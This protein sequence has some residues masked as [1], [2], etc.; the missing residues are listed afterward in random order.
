MKRILLS[1]LFILF[2]GCPI[3]VNAKASNKPNETFANLVFFA[4]YDGTSDE[5]QEDIKYYEK[6]NASFLEYYEGTTKRSLTN[7]LK[8]ISYGKFEVKNIFPQL[9][10]GKI[11]PIKFNIDIKD[12][13]ERNNDSALIEQIITAYPSLSN[14]MVDYNGDGYIDNLTIIIK[15]RPNYT[16]ATHSS[17]VSHKGDYPEAK[18]YLNKYIG[19]YNIV[20]TDSIEGNESGVIAHEFLH[21]LGYPD[22]YRSDA[23]NN[24]YP[25]DVWDIMASANRGM[26]YPL[27]YL[28]KHISNWVDIETITEST[29]LRLDLQSNPDGN[30][31]FILKSPLNDYEYFVVE[32]RKKDYN[33][34]LL[35][36]HIG[37]SGVIV[38]RVDT[39]VEGLSNHYG[40][41][42]VYVFRPQ[43]GFNSEQQKVYY[44]ALSQEAKRTSIGSSN[45]NLGL[46]DGALTFSDGS[47]S[48]IVIKNVSKAGGDFMTLDV[49]IPKAENFDLWQNK[50]LPDL[51]GGN[52]NTNKKITITNYKDTVYALSYGNNRLY[53]Q[54][55]ENNNWVTKGTYCNI[56]TEVL[57]NIKVVELNDTLYLIANHTNAI[58]VY[59]WN[60]SNHTWNL[61]SSYPETLNE[62]EVGV[63]QNKIY[64]AGS[65]SDKAVLYVL[66]HN[67]ITK[68]GDYYSGRNGTPKIGA[69]HDKVYVSIKSMDGDVLLY[70]YEANQFI[71]ISTG[72]N[73]NNYDLK[74][75]NHKLYI[76][77]GTNGLIHNPLSLKIF[78]GT[79]WETVSSSLT[80]SFPTMVNSQGNLYILGTD[81]SNLYTY[82]YQEDA[83]KFILEGTVVDTGSS[84]YDTSLVALNKSI[85]VG[86]K[87]LNNTLLVKAKEMS[88]HL[89]SLR[90]HTS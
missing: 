62:F 76:A 67:T 71:P 7:Y 13:Y 32:Y 47:N 8:E 14:K 51:I 2:V 31:A 70:R 50:N 64:I 81:N 24:D 9:E 72:I 41:T 54:A 57:T 86:I 15:D 58:H 27:A 88:N 33:I 82:S 25:V 49:E 20:N 22:L 60:D 38:Y 55:L 42:G 75:W 48:G 69:I 11:Q 87:K 74:S 83:K 73:T 17:F 63:I 4:Y 79:N 35:D 10:N 3:V 12:S 78:D 6:N 39:T 23:N 18:K 68:V 52:E 36:R 56:N 44:A 43:S 21:S 26:S 19:T 53:T 28:R 61:F 77:L 5:I 16:A 45:M 1:I 89:I 80:L 37:D 84:F 66:N 34:D 59:T 40:E 46:Q 30:Q 65:T 90:Y 29:T 85:Y